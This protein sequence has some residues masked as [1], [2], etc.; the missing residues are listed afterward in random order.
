MIS[1]TLFFSTSIMSCKAL[2]CKKKTNKK[3]LHSFLLTFPLVNWPMLLLTF[4]ATICSGF[5][6]A[7]LI[8][9][10]PILATLI[11]SWNAFMIVLILL[12]TLITAIPCNV[13]NTT[14]HQHTHLTWCATRI[15]CGT[16]G[17]MNW[18]MG[19]ETFLVAIVHI[20][21]SRALEVD[22]L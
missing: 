14:A 18:P 2:F 21:T 17:L 9:F 3:N 16:I 6:C 15:T 4:S 11:T 8:Q 13:T 22:F 12:K 19:I 10:Q 1:F 5:A 7:A 20:L